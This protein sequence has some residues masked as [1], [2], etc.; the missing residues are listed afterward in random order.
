MTDSSDTDTPGRDK[1][2][3]VSVPNGTDMSD[4]TGTDMSGS[5]SDTSVSDTSVSDTSVS[6]TSVPDRMRLRSLSLDRFGHFTDRKFDFGETGDAPDFHIIYGPNESGKTTT[7]EACLRLFYGFPLREGYAFRHQRNTLQVSGELEVGGRLRRFTRLPVRSGSLVDETGKALPETALSAHLAGW[8][9]EDYRTLLCL[10]DDTIERGGEEIAQAR[11]EI[12]RLLFSAA[13]GVADLSAVLEGVQE[14]AAAIWR[15]RASKTRVAGLKRDLAQT[16]RDIRESDVSAGA[17]RGLKKALADARDAESEA[18]EARNAL[19]EK[20]AAVSSRRRGVPLLAEVDGLE[21]RIGPF[22]AF[23]EQLDFDP[24]SLVGL[25]AEEGQARADIQRLTGDINVWTTVRDGIERVPELVALSGKLDALDDLRAR[26][27]TAG[28]D[29][30]RRRR[31]V[32]EAEAAMASAMRDLGAGDGVNPRDLVLSPAQIAA[33]ESAR[34]NLRTAREAAAAEAREVADL[35]VRGDRA[36]EDHDNVVSQGPEGQGIGDILGRH[37]VD[38]LAPAFARARQAIDEAEAAE[39]LAREALTVGGVRFETRDVRDISDRV[40]PDCPAS[41]IKAQ[42]WLDSQADLVRKIDETESTLAQH[43]ED[44]AV[45]RS[46]ADQLKAGGTLVPDDEV[47]VLEGERD[48]LWQA[49]R[50]ALDDEGADGSGA[51]HVGQDAAAGETSARPGETA[52]AFEAAMQTLDAAMRSRVAHARDLG[53]LRQTEQARAE[54]QARADQAETR[55]MA[56]R[57]EQVALQSEVNEAASSVGLPVP[58]SSAQ[59]LGWVCRHATAAEAA[60]KLESLRKEH[61]PE[62]DRAQRLLDALHPHLNLENPNFDSALAAARDLAEA[63]RETIFAATRARETLDVLE[64]E[65][66]RRKERQEAAREAAEQAEAAWCGMVSGCLGDAVAHETLFVSLEPLRTLR[67]YEEKRADMAQRVTTMEADQAQ[68]AREVAALVECIGHEA[69]DMLLGSEPLGPGSLGGESP[70]D[71]TTGDTAAATFAMLRERSDA[72]RDAQ[73]QAAELAAR[74]EDAGNA[75]SERQVRLDE[76]GQQVEAMGR[77]FPDGTP[78]GSLDDLRSAAVQAQQVIADRNEKGRKERAILSDLGVDDMGQAREMLKDTT[79]AGLEAEA[80]TI[81]ADLKVAETQLTRATEVR[82]NADRALSAVT[83][84]AGIA[85]LTERKATLELELE[86]AVLEHLELSLGHRL[87]DEAIRRYRD[88]HRSDMMA[89]TERCF[90]TL[91]Q[92]AYARLTTQ[93][94]GAD[95]ILLAIDGEGTAKRVAELSKGTRFQLYLALRAAAHAQLVEQGVCLPFFCDDI[96]E[97]FDEDRTSAACRVME[98]IGRKG[99]A[100]YFTH[101]RHVVDIA[102]QVCDTDPVVHEL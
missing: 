36:R 4:S 59:W 99:Q 100:I 72:A 93:P 47:E 14:D 37:D 85:A 27:V 56:L 29:L 70:E 87:A 80:E 1:V 74:I 13:A 97:T 75:V 63:E 30:A 16:E 71:A 53:Q 69:H 2:P 8:G 64:G 62:L 58:Q 7:M 44:V 32:Q 18:R 22:S 34:E 20:S 94:D 77:I 33:L 21:A 61:Q 83:G 45:R 98:D 90:A 51:E 19:H 26:D 86:E 17:W 41:E 65:L 10:D 12:G 15:K 101:H 57:V 49:H 78:V 9:E 42:A 91:T 11:G 68:F 89:A 88:T 28:L 5:V 23:P 25:L 52:D 40:G 31:E 95:E 76:I 66:A 35:T 43:R 84:D 38:R 39:R 96:F 82:V 3:S 24:E 46:Q 54:A 60:Q 92:G 48:R 50:L 81:E 73:A 6:D 102:R 67:A 55:L 79:S